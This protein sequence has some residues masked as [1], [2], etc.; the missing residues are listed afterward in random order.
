MNGFYDQ[1]TAV[2]KEHSFVLIRQGKG[3][4]RFGGKGRVSVAVSTNCNS[5]HTANKILKEA[6]IKRKF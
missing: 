5:R 2:L 3:I 1:V 4:I 6:G